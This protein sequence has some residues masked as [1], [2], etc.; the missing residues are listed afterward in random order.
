MGKWFRDDIDDR[1]ERI[2]EALW[3]GKAVPSYALAETLGV[4][5]RTIYRDIM[6]MRGM[7]VRIEGAAG[8]GYRLRDKA[9][10]LWPVGQN[11]EGD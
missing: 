9:G 10:K 2:M 11:R 4:S 5:K 6:K 8:C 1:Y 7:G 3:A